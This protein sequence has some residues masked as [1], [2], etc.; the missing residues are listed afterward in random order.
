MRCRIYLLTQ[1]RGFDHCVSIKFTHSDFD[2]DPIALCSLNDPTLGSG[3]KTAVPEGFNLPQAPLMERSK[4]KY[5]INEHNEEQQFTSPHL[6]AL[7][8]EFLH[9]AFDLSD[10]AFIRK[11]LSLANL[12]NI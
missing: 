12:T 9:E 4:K 6:K 5:L 1:P 2:M 10:P 8:S 3:S 11:Y 7:A